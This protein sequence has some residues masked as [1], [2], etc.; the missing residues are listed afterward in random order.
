MRYRRPVVTSLDEAWVEKEEPFV[1]IHYRDPRIRSVRIDVGSG[2]EEMADVDIIA[3]HNRMIEAG[4]EMREGIRYTAVEVPEGEP[5]IEYHAP[6]DQWTFRGDV[7]RCEIGS[8]ELDSPIFYID[9]HEL[10]LREFGRMMTVYS[11]W[12]V[13]III[14]PD[15]ELTGEPEII[16]ADPGKHESFEVKADQ[17]HVWLDKFLTV[18]LPRLDTPSIEQILDEYLT[19]EKNRVSPA[20]SRNYAEVVELLR[21]FLNNSGPASL[22]GGEKARFSAISGRKG[23]KPITFCDLYG[24]EVMCANLGV[25]LFHFMP[26]KVTA[27]EQMLRRA[28]TVA[29]RLC[30][31]LGEKAYIP[32]D[33]ADDGVMLGRQAYR[34]LPRAERAA[35]MLS[36]HA[37]HCPLDPDDLDEK[38]YLEFDHYIVQRVEPGR[39][40]LNPYDEELGIIG[41]VPVP[42]KASKLIEKDWEIG[43]TLG[44][45]EG[46]WTLMEVGNLHIY[47]E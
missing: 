25:F 44:R 19:A 17:K 34:A 9:D 45:H 4:Q 8:S 2:V 16:V 13:R 22:Y 15:D 43:C 36:G 10:T 26:G 12:G 30:G 47:P 27:D 23:V 40:W 39:I 33:L 38:D 21:L 18:E 24:P 14:V 5:Q 29:Q 41:P 37:S 11:G 42:D 32:P 35:S 1:Y 20:T 6:S 31:W 7:L 46:K 28:G 3:L